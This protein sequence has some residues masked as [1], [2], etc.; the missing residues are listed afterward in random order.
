MSAPHHEHST[1][2]AV[3]SLSLP[4]VLAFGPVLVG[5]CEAPDNAPPPLQVL[6]TGAFVGEVYVGGDS[7]AGATI[8]VV[9]TAARATSDA[10]R[11]FALYP[12]TVGKHT[13]AIVDAD[14][15][16]ARFEAALP[17]ENL[18]VTLAEADTTLEE[19]VRVSGLVATG[20]GS[21]PAGATAFVVG[22]TGAEVATVG[23]DGSFTITGVPVGARTIAVAR[24]G[25]DVASVDIAVAAGQAIVLDTP[26][27]IAVAPPAQLPLAG[28]VQVAGR[29]D[30]AGTLINV[31]DGAAITT[32]DA[33]GAFAVEV[34]PGRHVVR[35]ERAGFAP[36]ELGTV[37]VAADGAVSGL[38]PMFLCTGADAVAF[39]P[40]PSAPTLVLRAPVAGS[41]VGS[42]TPV[43][44]VADLLNA[45]AD[46]SVTDAEIEWRARGPGATELVVV[47]TGRSVTTSFSATTTAQAT[48]EARVAALDLVATTTITVA[49]E[50]PPVP[51]TLFIRSPLPGTLV[52]SGV[53]VTLSAGLANAPADGSLSLDQVEWYARPFGDVDFALLGTGG[54][55]TTRFA[56]AARNDID[57]EARLPSVGLTDA[58][59]VTVTPV[60]RTV[61]VAGFPAS[62]VVQ[63]T[64][65]DADGDGAFE[66]SVGEG[67]PVE[68]RAGFDDGDAV[69]WQAADGGTSFADA[70]PLGAL[71]VGTHRFTAVIETAQGL[72]DGAVV[73]V[74]VHAVR[75]SVAVVQPAEGVAFFSD[76][77]LP[78][79]IAAT[80]EFQR[81]FSTEAVRWSR[82]DGTALASGTLTSSTSAP[83][84]AQA[85]TVEVTDLV[86]NRRTALRTYERTPVTFT[87][88]FAQP[89]TSPLTVALGTPVTVDVSFAHTR[90]APND[91]S[92]RVRL[93]SSLS[94]AISV[95]GAADFAPNTPVQLT[96][97]PG[98]HVLTARVIAGAQTATAT[99]TVVV[100]A[101]FV[102]ALLTQPAA[103]PV[104][105]LET[106]GTTGS[107]V[108][109]ALT[110]N[111]SAGE[112]PRVSWFVDGTEFAPTW[113]N[114]GSDPTA[115]LR[116]TPNLGPYST[117]TGTFADPR[118][119]SGTHTVQAWVRLPAVEQAGITQC[120]TSGSASRCFTFAVTTTATPTLRATTVINA[121][122]TEVWSGVNL[123]TSSVTV[124]GTLIIEPGTTVLAD[125][126]SVGF[127]V[128][129][130]ATLKIGEVD[131][132]RVLMGLR[133]GRTGAWNGIVCGSIFG[134]GGAV[135]IDGLELRDAGLQV[136]A[137]AAPV[138]LRQI[139]FSGTA[140]GGLL[141]QS[142]VPQNEIGQ[143][144]FARTATS[145]TAMN[146]NSP[147]TVE[148]LFGV[149]R[150]VSVLASG[151]G[152][153][154]RRVSLTADV[155]SGQQGLTVQGPVRIEDAVVRAFGRGIQA[156]GP[157]II[158]RATVEFCSI[159]ISA[160]APGV[161]VQSSTLRAN[162]AAIEAVGSVV[163]RRNRFVGNF[164][165]VTAGELADL[166]G[167]DFGEPTDRTTT[168]FELA[169]AP[170]GTTVAL[171][172][173]GSAGQ[174]NPPPTQVRLDNAYTGPAPLAVI[175]Q[176]ERGQAIHPDFCLPLVADGAEGLDVDSCTWTLFDT[177]VADGTPLT[178]GADGCAVESVTPGEHGV[179]L[180][181]S[182]DGVTTTH[183]T[184][185]LVD[186]STV[187]GIVPARGTTLSGDLTVDRDVVIPV[188]ATLTIAP[189][190][191]LHPTGTGD[192]GRSTQAFVSSPT[193]DRGSQTTVEF[194][195]EGTLDIAGT[196]AN[197]VLIEP[198]T[199]T[200]DT[201]WG[202]IFAARDAVV[203]LNGLD[204][205]GVKTLVTGE[206]DPTTPARHALITMQDAAVHAPTQSTGSLV[207]ADICPASVA[208]TT[209]RNMQSLMTCVTSGDIDLDSLD[210]EAS[211]VSQ[212]LFRAGR[213]SGSLRLAVS[214]RDSRVVFRPQPSQTAFLYASGSGALPT[215]IDIDQTTLDG[216]RIGETFAPMA[217]TLTGTTIRGYNV[218]V[219]GRLAGG[220]TLALDGCRVDGAGSSY[221]ADVG[222]FF[223]VRN[224]TF[225]NLPAGF[226]LVPTTTRAFTLRGNRFVNSDFAVFRNASSTDLAGVYDLSGNDFSGAAN[227][228]GTVN[229]GTANF[230]LTGSF[231]GT[232]NRAAIEARIGDTRADVDPND[233][234]K[235]RS[236]YSGFLSAP[237]VLTA[238]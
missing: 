150:T 194:L 186:D 13:I 235:G 212:A 120:A 62:Q 205:T 116:R 42:G 218:F 114:Y 176:P 40:E 137:S 60:L 45:P 75:F 100:N 12:V 2:R 130:G 22:G 47:G 113:G 139:E 87:A 63:P 88:S 223:D 161:V 25:Y 149:N 219:L 208:R 131:S 133:E 51:P 164:F 182:L 32:T 10:E 181:C 99:T 20:D 232:T 158:E 26:L 35:A 54:T 197:P 151:A 224:S 155:A 81:A 204:V 4:F 168:A 189:G 84:G 39:E 180:T 221:F 24:P 5:G 46:G 37:S 153:T 183:S 187:G 172:R 70:L 128:G 109:F 3:L 196:A 165:D 73:V 108:A 234:I 38:V 118:W 28:S 89:S 34:A 159:G 85:L 27:T 106:P 71:P 44:L 11:Q 178:V 160:T 146:F 86:G 188:G 58:T 127:V 193:T 169:R 206:Q 125:S 121:G 202:G 57:I 16:A 225:T 173:I 236:D 91:P 136:F 152:V 177:V 41:L 14:G 200:A 78:L 230:D 94:G 30:H 210:F 214:L 82:E 132:A 29:S 175:V 52:G 15:R 19:P 162:G 74:E 1:R 143:L 220:V 53:A 179:A 185:I 201:A 142:S 148:D 7:V 72:V 144:T 117:S 192:R 134:P 76:T 228:L 237:P 199:G 233:T 213:T 195:V 56:S 112:T 231:F 64:L 156:N 111:A 95:G 36:V 167:N 198:T 227:V 166:R 103:S 83:T 141:V 69:V 67:I 222:E 191:R 77:P 207:F 126:A 107:D 123:L 170:V 98:T 17:T 101:P 157:T 145:T 31:D 190:T 33:D 68:L 135:S 104:V 174:F 79:Q 43:S 140:G 50:A 129:L 238:P 21:S 80:H 48:I 23:D 122:Q 163:A 102:T 8:Q 105:L 211:A 6:G 215:S 96:L 92:V 229:D 184:R 18:T 55:L 115:A 93:S 203:R 217:I 65:T 154:L 90:I 97:A 66:L 147:G 138:R 124:N 61:V 59:L 9:G 209:V 49:P 110:V 226:L 119:A 216:L 171:P